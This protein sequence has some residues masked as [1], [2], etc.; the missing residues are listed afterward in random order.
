ML[1]IVNA[2]QL[3]F[4]KFLLII[5]WPQFV[6]ISSVNQLY[7]TTATKGNPTTDGGSKFNTGNFSSNVRCTCF[8]CLYS[9]CCMCCV[10]GDTLQNSYCMPWLLGC[11]CVNPFFARNTIR[12]QYRLKTTF[13]NNECVEECAIPYIFYC[14][15]NLVAT[16]IPLLSPIAYC[17]WIAVVM[18]VMNMREEVSLRISSSSVAVEEDSLVRKKA[19][20]VGYSPQ[21][22]EPSVHD[23]V[24]SEPQ[25]DHN[26]AAVDSREL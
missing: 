24:V 12:Y 3:L 16:A 13:G 22:T 20:L 1:V 8:P 17:Q 11:L 21:S 10:V 2:Y 18:T 14:F 4:Y 26:Y 6:I 23:P 5:E 25:G 19:Y 7:Q 15:I 9:C